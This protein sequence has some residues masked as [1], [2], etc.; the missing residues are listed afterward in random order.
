MVK[1]SEFHKKFFEEK[2]PEHDMLLKQCIQNWERFIIDRV[3]GVIIERWNE[4]FLKVLYRKIPK[5]AGFFIKDASH[6]IEVP[7]KID[8]FIVGYAD[9]LFK[10]PV[11]YYEGTYYEG[12]TETKTENIKL[13][14]EVKPKL[15]S[16]TSAFRQIKTY[17]EI[18]RADYGAIATYSEI[19]KNFIE[20]L[21][22]EDITVV[23]FPYSEEKKEEQRRLPLYEERECKFKQLCRTLNIDTD[24]A[25]WA[26]LEIWKEKVG[27]KNAR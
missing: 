4:M 10:I 5:D 14:V 26:L 16:V 27:S 22:N 3:D 19:E 15:K 20:I 9:L 13:V 21:E 7:C 2:T 25:L 12:I 6:E 18:L 8:K 1:P 24:Q 11:R 17:K 23:T